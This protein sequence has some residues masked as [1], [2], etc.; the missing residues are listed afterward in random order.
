MAKLS[1]AEREE[2]ERQLAEDDLQP[3][4]Y[5]ADDFEWYEDTPDGQRKGGRT[6]VRAARNHG[7]AWVKEFFAAPPA[8]DE[9]DGQAK[10]S[11]KDSPRQAGYFGRRAAGQ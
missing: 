9:G 1:K 11:G 8:P 5:D 2:L 4:D 10:G 6:S 7:P 3:A